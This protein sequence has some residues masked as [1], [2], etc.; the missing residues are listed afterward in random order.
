[1]FGV[2]V[3][4]F[5]PK[6]KSQTVPSPNSAPEKSLFN[7][8]CAT[9]H[10]SPTTAGHLVDVSMGCYA[11]AH[12]HGLLRGGAC[13]WKS[14]RTFSWRD[15][16]RSDKVPKWRPCRPFGRPNPRKTIKRLPS[17]GTVRTTV[18]TWRQFE[19]SNKNKWP[20]NGSWTRRRSS[21]Q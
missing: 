21:I 3:G 17:K 2:D 8:T 13:P 10:M 11:E 1:V 7:K 19:N 18:W 6:Q 16:I 9:K 4:S 5:R 14:P 12:A 15:P 20:A